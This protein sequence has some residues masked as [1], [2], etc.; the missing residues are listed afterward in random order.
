[1]APNKPLTQRTACLFSGGKAPVKLYKVPMIR[2]LAVV[3][4]LV[5]THA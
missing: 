1:L 5:H 2:I 3:A 4:P